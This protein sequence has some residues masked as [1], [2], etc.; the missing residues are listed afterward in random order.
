M[1]IRVMKYIRGTSGMGIKYYTEEYASEKNGL[2]CHTDSDHASD[3]D[4]VISWN[5][6]VIS[7]ASKKLDKVISVSTMEREYYYAAALGGKEA[8]YMQKILWEMSNMKCLH[9]YQVNIKFS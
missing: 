1:L 6:S 2:T 4:L 5:G 8:M 3:S 7:W 9:F